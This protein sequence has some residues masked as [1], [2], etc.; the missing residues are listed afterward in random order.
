MQ[1]FSMPFLFEH[2][3]YMADVA[4]IRGKDHIQYSISARDQDLLLEYGTQVV[5]VFDGK[6]MEFAF[7]G[8]TDE[9]L[10]FSKALDAGLRA[11]LGKK[12]N[13]VAEAV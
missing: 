7:P 12:T 3:Q 2:R 9:K 4:T 5:H 10:A 13:R 11:H 8:M 1:N 6:P